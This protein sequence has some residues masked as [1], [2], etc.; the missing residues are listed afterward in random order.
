[1]LTVVTESLD[2]CWCRCAITLGISPEPTMFV[3]FVSLFERYA[4]G[5]LNYFVVLKV[6]LLQ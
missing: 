1:M 4:F 2:L 6:Y 3:C 5:L